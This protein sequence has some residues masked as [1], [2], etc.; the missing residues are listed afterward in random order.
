MLR[1]VFGALLLFASCQQPDRTVRSPDG[2]FSLQ[3]R[4]MRHRPQ[5]LQ[6]S[7]WAELVGPFGLSCGRAAFDDLDVSDLESG[8]LV[9]WHED[10]VT[11]RGVA[12]RWTLEPCRHEAP[13]PNPERSATY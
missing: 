12:G 1:P 7:G 6:R 3:A 10:F 5:T 2:R 9:A 11:V 8:P 4:A 13:A